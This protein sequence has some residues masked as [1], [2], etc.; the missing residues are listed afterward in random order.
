M[1]SYGEVRR[2][3]PDVIDTVGRAVRDRKHSLLGLS[4]ELASSALSR[5]WHGDGATAAKKSLA[6]LND[7]AEHIVA[8][9]SAVQKALF[10]ASDGVYAV[11]Q[12]VLNLDAFAS[13]WQ[14]AI[15]ADGAIVDNAPDAQADPLR[16]LVRGQLPTAV[17]AIITQA[18]EVDRALAAVLTA[19]ASGAISDRGASSLAEADQK[20]Q[21]QLTPEEILARYQVNPDPNGMT[22][23]LGK[24][25]TS[26]EAAM[27]KQ[28][29]LLGLKNFSDLK[30]DAFATADKR[31]P[32]KADRNDDH[33]D[34]FRHAYWNALMTRKYGADWAKRYATA[35]EGIPG[36]PPEREAMDLYNN[37]VGRNIAIAHPN[38]S[39]EQLAGLVEDAVKRGDTVVIPARGGLDYSDR[40]APDQTGHPTKEAPE[41]GVEPKSGSGVGSGSAAASGPLSGSGS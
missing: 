24:T 37:E 35:H 14:F 32:S 21:S 28:L 20:I 10:S 6:G 41:G 26:T 4:D 40:V 19:A 25:V 18:T 36:N 9:A 34:A 15:T 33:N 5:R 16:G 3:N 13:S 1:V 31:F 2:W 30:D 29:G 8:E 17:Q 12:Q 38:A 22:T 39:P 23:L 27:L 11:R 7:R